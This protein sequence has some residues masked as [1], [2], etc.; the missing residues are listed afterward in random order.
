MSSAYSKLVTL[1]PLS[2]PTPN[3]ELFSSET[4]SFIKIAK[5]VGEIVSHYLTPMGHSNQSVA[6]SFR[7]TLDLGFLN[8]EGIA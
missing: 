6:R 3:P 1:K 7:I 5:R 4:R 2:R 8:R